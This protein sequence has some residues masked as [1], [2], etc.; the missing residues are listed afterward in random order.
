MTIR[1]TPIV[2]LF[3]LTAIPM[4]RAQDASATIQAAAEALGMLRGVQRRMDSINTIQF[5]GMG[6][7][8]VPESD[9]DWVQY[10]VADLT[11]G[12]S[13]FIPA[14]R[15]D[16]TSTDSAGQMERAIAVVRNDQAWD[17]AEP[18]VGA[19]P[20]MDRV[21]ARLRQIWLTPHGIVRA[22]VDAEAATPGSVEVASGGGTTT[23]TV[24]VDGVPVTATLNDDF[25]PERVEMPIDHPVLG[26]TLL[27][28]IYSDYVDWPILDVY[29]PSRIV[30][31]LDGETSLDLEVTSFFQNPYVVFP[32]PQ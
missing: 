1:A 10:D 24:V 32:M 16:M 20:A 30:H 4:A 12:M 2:L 25:R 18:G 14:M 15:W 23:L 13:Y 19:T 7:M 22:A 3:A 21:A 9:G 8:R 26:D 6:V 17:E 29:F 11:V 28:A 27:E 31:R 5:S